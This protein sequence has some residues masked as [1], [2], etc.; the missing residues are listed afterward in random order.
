MKTQTYPTEAT[1][2]GQ[3]HQPITRAAFIAI[4]AA[5]MRASIGAYAAR[6]HFLQHSGAHSLR[7]YRIACQL[8]ALT[9]WQQERNAAQHGLDFTGSFAALA[10]HAAT[11][12]SLGLPQH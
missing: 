4:K 12:H 9:H 2:I 1:Y 8:Q 6:Q 3:H 5:A 10:G 11:K 7:L